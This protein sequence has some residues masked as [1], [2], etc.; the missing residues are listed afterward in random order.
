MK[1]KQ[2]TL[3]EDATV[4][5][6]EINEVLKRQGGRAVEMM[7]PMKVT[8]KNRMNQFRM[9]PLIGG[10]TFNIEACYAGT[11]G[12]LIFIFKPRTPMEFAHME[13]DLRK[14]ITHL[15]HF[16]DWFSELTDKLEKK[17]LAEAIRNAPP[18]GMGDRYQDIDEYGAW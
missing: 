1:S 8:I 7:G 12:D 5:A 2:Q 18:P 11:T 4:L 14:A 10:E 6:K 3:V 16:T 13:M 17:N 15:H 9:K